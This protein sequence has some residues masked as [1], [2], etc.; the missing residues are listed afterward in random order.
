MLKREK[1]SKDNLKKKKSVG[2][3]S[4]SKSIPQKEPEPII[5]TTGKTAYDQMEPEPSLMGKIKDVGKTVV[6]VVSNP[7]QLRA[8]INTALHDALNPLRLHEK[9][10][11]VEER[12]TTKIKQA[13]SAASTINNILEQGVFDNIHDRYTSRSLKS[14]YAENGEVWKKVTKGLP[15]VE[16]SVEDLNAYR[17]SKEALK[18]QKKGLKSGID[19]QKATETVAKLK[20]K[21][22]PIDQRIHDY[23]RGVVDTYGKDML[24]PEARKQWAQES[25]ASLYR[26]MDYGK[27]AAVTEG[28]LNPK[29]W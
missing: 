13:Q 29:K 21:Y 4:K 9:D 3:K 5:E 12:V 7:K 23:Q 17:L 19:T 24:T 27:D 15:D 1:R 20:Q 16:Y 18:R 22:G 10:I 2:Q 28:S 25:H 6:D 26:A 14:A 8:N 11:P